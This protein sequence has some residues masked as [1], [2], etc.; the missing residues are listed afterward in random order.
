M[1]QIVRKA[2]LTDRATTFGESVDSPPPSGGEQEEEEAQGSC[3]SPEGMEL[4]EGS[5]G[6]GRGEAEEAAAK[7]VHTSCCICRL[8]LLEGATQL[9]YQ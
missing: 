6:A 2:T 5:S 8:T 4:E 3:R 1:G 9:V 7:E